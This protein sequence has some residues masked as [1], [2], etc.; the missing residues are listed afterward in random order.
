MNIY[1][2]VPVLITP[3][4]VVIVV[5]NSHWQAAEMAQEELHLLYNA[6]FR[7]LKTK[8][9]DDGSIKFMMEHSKCFYLHRQLPLCDAFNLEPHVIWF[10][11]SE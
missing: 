2:Y 11:Y 3:R 8:P 6:K 10:E 5:A 4:G 7:L 1:V 9:S